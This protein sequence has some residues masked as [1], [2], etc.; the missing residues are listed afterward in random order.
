MTV[1]PEV[2]VKPSCTQTK[3]FRGLDDGLGQN[4][5]CHHLGPEFRH[6]MV[7]KKK[8]AMGYT[9]GEK[10]LFMSKTWRIRCFDGMYGGVVPICRVLPPRGPSSSHPPLPH[11]ACPPPHLRAHI[12]CFSALLKMAPRWR[13]WPFKWPKVSAPSKNLDFHGKPLEWP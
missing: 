2:Q 5:P 13:S 12:C 6:L 9:F 11:H 8:Y 4:W 1:L 10:K 3:I 7:R